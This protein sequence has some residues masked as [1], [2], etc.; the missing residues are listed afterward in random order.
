MNLRDAYGG[1]Y[2]GHAVNDVLPEPIKTTEVEKAPSVTNVPT[3]SSIPDVSDENNNVVVEK[4]TKRK[5]KESKLGVEMMERPIYH[6][7]IELAQDDCHLICM[8][9]VIFIVSLLVSKKK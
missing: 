6:I 5:I 1:K 9:L 2:K 4:K 8:F 3:V 7:S